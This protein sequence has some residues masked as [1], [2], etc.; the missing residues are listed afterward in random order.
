MSFTRWALPCSALLGMAAADAA[1]AWPR[2]QALIEAATNGHAWREQ[3]H[4]RL[5][6]APMAHHFRYDEEH[7]RVWAVALERQRYDGWLLGGSRFSN[8]FGQPSAYLYLGHRFDSPFGLPPGFFGQVSAGLMYGYRGRF[9]DKV[10]LNVNGFSP[11]ALVSMGWQFER[12]ASAMLHMLGD[13]GVMLQL[14]WDIR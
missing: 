4:W 12:R 13:A 8:S 7:R 9:A 2:T 14:S 3:A 5:A 10:P 11:G 1:T 6:A